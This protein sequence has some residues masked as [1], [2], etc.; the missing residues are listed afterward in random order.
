MRY[1]FKFP[2]IGEGVTE[3]KILQWHVK[4]GQAIKTGD[5]LVK[6]E[7]DK[8]VTDIP[9]PKDGTIT[10]IFGKEGDVIK[11]NEPLVELDIEGVSGEEA[12]KVAKEKPKPKEDKPVEEKGG[13]VVGTLEEAG[14]SA[15]LSAGTEGMPQKEEPEEEKTKKKGL[16]TPVA[17][18][19]AKDM[20]IDINQVTGSGPGGR[21]TKEDIQHVHEKKQSGEGKRPAE[22]AEK[23]AEPRVKYE[24]LT[25]IRKA[26]ARNMLHSKQSTAHMTAIDEVEVSK[27]VKLRESHKQD[28]E[29]RGVKLSYLPFIIKSIVLTLMEFPRLNGELDLENER[30]ILKNYYNIGIAVDTQEGLVVP[31]IRDADKLSIFELSQ[32]ISELANQ[33][34]ERKLSLEDFKDGTFTVTNYGSI[35]GTYG[36]PVIN[37]PQVAI[38]GVGRI[39]KTPVVKDDQIAVGHV[40]PLSMS[41][42]HRIVDGAEAARFL[43]KLIGFLKD[44]VSLLLT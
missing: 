20:G 11:V 23:P 1:I 15:Y 41:V 44:P 35:G 3:G 18:A 14:D 30:M 37:Y 9:S 7:T 28:Y 21:I 42:D 29:D 17:R 25:Q 38:L 36:V 6:M 26:I 33:A 16:A 32:T 2:D 24:P 10:N 8:V 5:S 4:K 27:L 13:G 43:V 31:V 34:R 22:G 12:Q 39:M 40:L 19:M